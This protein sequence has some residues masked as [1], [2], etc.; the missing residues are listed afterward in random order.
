MSV[1]L[2]WALL[3]PSLAS[4]LVGRLNAS[5]R[6]LSDSGSLPEFLGDLELHSLDFGDVPAEVTLVE[7][8][9]VSKDLVEAAEKDDGVRAQRDPGGAASLATPPLTPSQSPRPSSDEPLRPSSAPKPSLQ[10]HFHVGYSGNMRIS[11]N[12]SLLVNY[13]SPLFM[14]LPLKLSVV[15][16]VLDAEV[17]LAVEGD[18]SRVHVCIVEPAFSSGTPRSGHT[19]PRGLGRQS[20]HPS[21]ED[22]RRH[23][24]DDAGKKIIPEMVVET[25]VGN[26]DR[27]VLRN[28]GKVE[29][30]VADVIRKLVCDELLFPVCLLKRFHSTSCR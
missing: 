22:L 29:R 20:R 12:A 1:D 14:A 21:G 5:L 10:L 4:S 17:V 9:D 7:M 2:D 23:A 24:L 16:I 27:H 18:R 28:V 13:P 3:G 8:G 26:S 11:L 30:F 15:G 6:A 25:E 19:P